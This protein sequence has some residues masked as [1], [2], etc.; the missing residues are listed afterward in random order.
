MAKKLYGAAAAARKKRLAKNKRSRAAKRRNPPKRRRAAPKRR[1]LKRNP[2]L[3][4]AQRVA[5]AKKG[6]RKRRYN[7]GAKSYA[8]GYATY[9]AKKK[10]KPAKKKAAAKKSGGKMTKAQRSAAAK[11]GWRN[12]RKGKR[13]GV[14]KARK[15]TGRSRK[16]AARRGSYGLKKMK[17]S[18]AGILRAKKRKGNWRTRR[19]MKKHNIMKVNPSNGMMDAVKQVLPIA[20]SFYVSKLI[21]NKLGDIPQVASLTSKLNVGGYPLGKPVLSGIIL[22]GVHYG[23][24]KGGLAKHRTALMLGTALGLLDSIVS[25]FAP[26]NVKALMGVGGYGSLGEYV[27]TGEYVSSGEY[28]SAGEYVSTDGYEEHAYG[29]SLSGGLYDEPHGL[30]AVA[31]IDSELGAI[32]AGVDTGVNNGIFSNG[33]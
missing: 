31:D 11:K 19:F 2:P 10:R 5:N 24:K 8:S 1:R 16:Q 33:W 22:A 14:S 32:E 6:W 25:T 7:S 26:A 18:R 3:T 15:R 30:Y 28:V 27:S 12:R 4:K 17:R 20:G 9:A 21:V 29:T 23:T 13:T